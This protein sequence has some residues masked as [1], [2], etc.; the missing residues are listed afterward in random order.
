MGFLNNPD[1]MEI[2]PGAAEAIRLINKSGYLA[3]IVSNQP[4][5]AR[6]EC[7]FNELEDIHNKLETLLGYE[8]AFVDAIYYCPH[9]TDKGFDGEIAEL[10]FNCNCRKPKAGL[11]IEASKDLNIDLN[12]SVMIG[13]SQTDIEAGQNAGC[14]QVYLVDSNTPFALLNCVH[15]I[16]G[17]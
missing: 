1:Q 3:V 10:K 13:D 6:G 15:R 14:S 5:I 11:F 9:H 7:T 17:V 16:L 4:V 12:N 2:I 8:G